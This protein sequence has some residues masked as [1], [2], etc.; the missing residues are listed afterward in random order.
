MQRRIKAQPLDTDT[1]QALIDHKQATLNVLLSRIP[2]I[3]TFAQLGALI[4]YSY[5][6]VRQRLIQDPEKLYRNGKRYRVPKGVAEEFV[7]SVFS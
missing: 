1:Y 4:G 3:S 2:E 5:E 6:W 7:K